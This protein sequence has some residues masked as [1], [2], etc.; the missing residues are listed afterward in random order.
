MTGGPWYATVAPRSCEHCGIVTSDWTVQV[1]DD[2]GGH[3]ESVMCR[4][5]DPCQ[6]RH[7]D[8]HA[9]RLREAAQTP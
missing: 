6:D 8:A 3:T 7:A 4:D 2:D 5:A 1:M 9:A